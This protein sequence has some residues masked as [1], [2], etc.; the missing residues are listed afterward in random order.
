[1]S[2][3]KSVRIVK[4]EES[5]SPLA[6]R[7]KSTPIKTITKINQLA[8][9]TSFE[10]TKSK[11]TPLKK[12]KKELNTLAITRSC[13]KRINSENELNNDNDISK[14][15]TDLSNASSSDDGDYQ[16]GSD[17]FLDTTIKV[18]RSKNTLKNLDWSVLKSV[19]RSSSSSRKCLDDKDNNF[20]EIVI[21]Y[22]E[23]E[24]FSKV[25]SL[26]IK[27]FNVILFGLGSKKHLLDAFKD[28]WLLDE[29]FLKICGYFMELSLRCILIK[30][31]KLFRMETT[32]ENDFYEQAARLDEDIYL[33]IHSIDFLFKTDAKIKR[34]LVNLISKCNGK[35]HL[36]ATV[37]HIN[38]A[39]AFDLKDEQKLNLVYL[40]ATTYAN[41]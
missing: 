24:L 31:S 20:K 36:I 41:F 25:Y 27:N 6:T 29:R 32:N 3:R 15:T 4:K 30:L 18:K 34:F 9:S 5:N 33:I 1:M 2:T 35:L 23:C 8:T 37:D 7:S 13:R 10:T 11:L 40:E 22:Y 17:Y 39:L 28:K 19:D 14:S 16:M 26:L 21:D 12:Q 38:S